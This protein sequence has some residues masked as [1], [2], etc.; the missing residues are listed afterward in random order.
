[1]YH[2]SRIYNSWQGCY[3]T[4]PLSEKTIVESHYPYTISEAEEQCLSILCSC[5]SCFFFFPLDFVGW[6]DSVEIVYL[7]TMWCQLGSLMCLWSLGMLI[8]CWLILD[9]VIHRSSGW[10][11]FQWGYFDLHP[12][13]LS[14]GIA[15]LGSSLGS[16]VPGECRSL[17]RSWLRN[18]VMS[19]CYL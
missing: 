4:L 15:S 19:F 16:W 12:R 14:T 6:Q 10:M 1:M 17:L 7:C 3:S 11:R 5:V 8:W 9:D 2:R 13:S 18:C